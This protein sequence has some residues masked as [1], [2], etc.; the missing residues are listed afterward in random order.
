MLQLILLIVFLGAAYYTF[1]PK[2]SG[3]GRR[4]FKKDPGSPFKGRF[5]KPPPKARNHTID[6][7]TMLRCHNCGCFFSESRVVNKV[8]EGHVLEFCTTN[9]R[10]NFRFPPS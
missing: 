6:K 3:K 2:G 7:G 5:T 9:C 4:S 1:S 10:D 8:V